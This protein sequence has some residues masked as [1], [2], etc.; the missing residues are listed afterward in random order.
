MLNFTPWS[1]LGGGVLIGAAAVL[2]L[3]LPGRVAGCSGIA[4]GLWFA[5]PG[6]RL[7]R[8]FFLAGL[9]LGTGA[10]VGLHHATP[11]PRAA[12]PVPLLAI[13]GLLVGYGTSLSGGC[14]SGH[15]VCGLA[16]LSARSLV[17]TLVFLGVA[18]LTTVTM[19]H[20]LHLG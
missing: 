14:T 9:V 19:R 13:A 12:F 7:W 20:V 15:G 6:E 11:A 4:G 5:R 16:R 18:I 10:W 3:G 8:V 2:L 1:A 17:A